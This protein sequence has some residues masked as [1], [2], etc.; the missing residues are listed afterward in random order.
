MPRPAKAIAPF[1]SRPHPHLYEINTWVWLEELSAKH[2]RRIHLGNVPPEEWDALA[3]LGFDYVWLMGVW[4]RSPA[5]RKIA[6][7]AP[8]LRAAYDTVLPGWTPDDVV[9]SPYSI[10][11]YTPDRRIGTWKDLD[12]ARA[13]L[14]RRGLG[15]ILDFVPNHTAL[16]HP[17]TRAHPDYYVQGTAADF[18]RDP[19]SFFRVTPKS[20]GRGG[21]PRFLAHGRDPYF[22]AWTDTAQLNYFNPELRAALLEEIRALAE[23]CDGLRCDMAMLVLNDVFAR[24]WENFLADQPRPA[25][26]FWPDAVAAAPGLLWLAEVYWDFEWTMHQ[27]GFH[28]AY[29]KRLYDRLCHHPGEVRSHLLAEW[30]YQCKLARFLENHDEPRAA[31]AFGSERLE[32]PATLIAT[33]P[34]M[35]LYHHGQFDAVRRRWP[36]QLG[37]VAPEPPDPA[38]RELYQRLLALSHEEVFHSGE[39]RLLEVEP[40]GDRTHEDLLAFRWRAQSAYRLIVVNL[41]PGAS[42]G[43][44]PLREEFDLA[45][46]LV[47]HDLLHDAAYE[48]RHEDLA[49]YGLYVRLEPHRAHLFDVRP[50]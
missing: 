4:K 49:A 20:R 18:K 36:V 32:A 23:H 16:D 1:V 31:E 48:R 19:T 41:G 37:R 10:P 24:T 12:A 22:P 25:T 34:G 11:A 33:L 47:F 39:W 17:W 50:L 35:C 7:A 21:S 5:S 46:D 29:D 40:C 42:Q 9:G 30:D 26:E 3:A 44:L 8:S 6:R 14:R 2:G 43:H 28:F 38:C 13:Q 45:R 27:L 15:L